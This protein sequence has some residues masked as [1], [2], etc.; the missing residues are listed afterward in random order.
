MQLNL[1]EEI[2]KTI[3]ELKEAE[4]NDWKWSFSDYPKEKKN[5][6]VFSCF[7]CGGG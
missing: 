5:I 7:A 3:P 4:S 1:F 6:T 2:S